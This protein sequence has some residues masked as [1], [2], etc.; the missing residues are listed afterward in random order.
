M[1][2]KTNKNVPNIATRNI[3]CFKIY[4]RG[5]NGFALTPYQESLICDT[6]LKGIKPFLPF[7]IYFNPKKIEEIN[8]KKTEFA[9]SSGYIHTYMYYAHAKEHKEFLENNYEEKF[10]VAKCIIPKGYEYF[11]GIDLNGAPGYASYGIIFKI[12]NYEQIKN[13]D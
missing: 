6:E 9:V 2:L 1:C 5:E 8:S 4:K 7:N 13:N 12:E 11:Q 10:F 3:D